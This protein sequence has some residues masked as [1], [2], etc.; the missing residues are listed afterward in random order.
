MDEAFL[1]QLVNCLPMGA[2]IV[3]T[4]AQILFANSQLSEILGYE[5]SELI[6]MNIDSLL[7]AQFKANHTHLMSQFFV[8]PR[9]RLMGEGREL[10]A[11]KKNGKQIP[12]E[13]GL[14]PIHGQQELVLATLVDIS[15]RLRANNMFQ[16]S[17]QAA[18]HGVLIVDQAGI[19]QAVNQ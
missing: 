11:S 18:P 8:N 1:T 13:I 14:N 2:M 17:I 9:K 15:Q 5:D 7:P 12:I 3:N 16:R 10:F 6:G 19:I 4:D